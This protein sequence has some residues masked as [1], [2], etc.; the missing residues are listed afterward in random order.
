ML[1]LHKQGLVSGDMKKGHQWPQISFPSLTEASIDLG[2]YSAILF[3][4]QMTEIQLLFLQVG[5]VP[6]SH[7][8]AALV[9]A[10]W[11]LRLALVRVLIREG[12]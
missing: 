9:K 4:G 12:F 7:V 1:H 3:G 6:F 10:S 2:L 11:P 8:F 5:T